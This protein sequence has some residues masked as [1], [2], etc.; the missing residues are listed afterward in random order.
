MVINMEISLLITWSIIGLLLIALSWIEQ[1]VYIKKN[2]NKI[3]PFFLGLYGL[4]VCFLVVDGFI[5]NQNLLATFNLIT[6]I[7]VIIVFIQIKKK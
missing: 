1:I 3:S 4:G 2:K 7:F 6:F 5:N